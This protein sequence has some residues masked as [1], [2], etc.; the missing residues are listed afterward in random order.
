V[1]AVNLAEL[2]KSLEAFLKS[3]GALVEQIAREDDGV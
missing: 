3:G 2:A 1:S